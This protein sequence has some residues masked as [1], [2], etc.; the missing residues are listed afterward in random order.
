MAV[1]LPVNFSPA[2]SVSCGDGRFSQVAKLEAVNSGD[3]RAGNPL[4]NPASPLYFG[5][6]GKTGPVLSSNPPHLTVVLRLTQVANN[7]SLK[8]KKKKK[9]KNK[10]DTCVLDVA[11]ETTV[12]PEEI[13]QRSWRLMDHTDLK[14][15]TLEQRSLETNEPLQ[16]GFHFDEEEKHTPW[17]FS[18]VLTGKLLGPKSRS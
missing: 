15:Q 5:D 8:E 2:L 1:F 4:N 10:A 3:Y 7:K 13:C 11:L 17:L 18:C 6:S 9:K 14:Q 12:L 16:G